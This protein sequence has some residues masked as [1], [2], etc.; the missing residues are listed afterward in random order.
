MFDIIFVLRGFNSLNSD[1]EDR[2]LA[3]LRAAKFVTLLHIRPLPILVVAARYSCGSG[4]SGLA[5]KGGSRSTLR[6][7]RLQPT[8]DRAVAASWSQMV[9]VWRE[10]RIP[11]LCS[12]DR[13]RCGAHVRPRSRAL[14]LGTLLPYGRRPRP[15]ATAAKR[16]RDELRNLDLPVLPESVRPAA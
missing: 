4:C 11:T 12:H 2:S 14:A 9:A 1:V 3:Y 6:R 8:G 10:P 16:T 5:S 13:N 15:S 7:R